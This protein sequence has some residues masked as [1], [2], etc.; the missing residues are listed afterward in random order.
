MTDDN[1]RAAKGG[2][3]ITRDQLRSIV[4]RI[5]TIDAEIGDLNDAKKEIFTEAKGNGYNVKVLRLMIRRRKMD[6][7]ERDELDSLLG[8]Y[9]DVFS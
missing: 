8:L 4:E 2:N 9:E 1:P 5:E 3:S 7:D 6:K